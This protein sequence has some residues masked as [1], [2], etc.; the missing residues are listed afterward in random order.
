MEFFIG[1]FSEG[2]DDETYVYSTPGLYATRDDCF[3]ALWREY[4]RTDM[5]PYDLASVIDN[6]FSMWWDEKVY[7]PTSDFFAEPIAVVI[8]KV[9]P[10]DIYRH[11]Q[12]LRRGEDANQDALSELNERFKVYLFDLIISEEEF[13]IIIQNLSVA[14]LNNG[15]S[16][17]YQIKRLPCL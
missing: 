3:R 6:V 14:A 13:D 1:I 16:F 12:A 9:I 10:L 2:H 5:L 8:R 17:D 11:A 4:L 7:T 15:V